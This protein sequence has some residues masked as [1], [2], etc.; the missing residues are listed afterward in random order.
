MSNPE[1]E[2]AR[3]KAEMAFS[4]LR[5]VREFDAMYAL[6]HEEYQ[7]AVAAL[8]AAIRAD[9]LRNDPIVKGLVEAL[10]TGDCLCPEHWRMSVAALAAY[11]EAT[12]SATRTS[13]E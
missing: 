1:I 12:R 8:E 13:S 7:T 2:A 6:R 4:G 9:I 5:V 10:R 3:R 11:E